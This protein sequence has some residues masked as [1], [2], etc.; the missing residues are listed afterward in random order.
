MI[1]TSHSHIISLNNTF[2]KQLEWIQVRQ[3]DVRIQKT[4][5]LGVFKLVH[6]LSYWRFHCVNLVV[7]EYVI[8]LIIGN[9]C[10]IR[11][12]NKNFDVF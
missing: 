2:C 5:F 3:G 10:E 7:E 11:N 6:W 1:I 9:R 8:F 12:Q 4:A